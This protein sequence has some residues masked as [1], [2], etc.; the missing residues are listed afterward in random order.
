M[1]RLRRANVPAPACLAR[2][3][4]GRDNWN[5]LKAA[6]RAQLRAQL[7]ALQGRRC[8]YCEGDLDALG[9]HI[10]HL[11][12]KGRYPKLTFAWANLF[13]SCDVADS[14]GRFKDHDAGAFNPA[15]LID[16]SQEDP[17]RFFR[18]RSDGSITVRAGLS[19]ADEHRAKETLRV[20][21]LDPDNRRLRAMRRAA[22]EAYLHQDPEIAATLL[23]FDESERRAIIEEELTKTAGEPFHTVIRHI[24]LD[25]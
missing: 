5:D 25:L 6:D 15:D 12:P 23:E 11:W 19:P 20:F 1:K 18:F 24:F 13:G 9:E 2:F 8:A 17:D 21:N 7:D 10:E 22:A 4:H 14:C 3:H 16:P